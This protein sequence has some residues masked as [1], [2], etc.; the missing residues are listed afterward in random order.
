MPETP[1]SSS[2]GQPI[3]RSGAER[4]GAQVY[5]LV[6][7]CPPGR[8]TTY[9]WIGAAMGYPF[10]AEASEQRLA[11]GDIGLRL[12]AL[13]RDAVDDAKD[14]APLFG[15][16]DDH[17]NGVGGG[18]VDV[19]DLLDRAHRWKHVDGEGVA[20]QDEEGMTSA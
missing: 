3:N 1:S 14:A 15:L 12:D 18:A 13:C 16:C 6:R 9:G 8:V 20:Q 2:A 10:V 19:A 17:L 4:L 5:A 11:L 7:A